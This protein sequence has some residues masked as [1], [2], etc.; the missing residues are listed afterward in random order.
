M[1]KLIEIYEN[2]NELY[3]R[4]TINKCKIVDYKNG[5]EFIFKLYDYDFKNNKFIKEN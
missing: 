1:Y 2:G 4:N 3:Y 5:K